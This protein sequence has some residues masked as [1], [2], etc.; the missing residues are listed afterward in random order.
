M[1][2]RERIVQASRSNDLDGIL[3]TSPENFYYATGVSPH[4]LSVSRIPGFA[5][6][7]LD[8]RPQ[9]KDA[10]ITMDY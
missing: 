5:Y 8:L 6:A 1:T 7:F 2:T 4:Q 3:V 9:Q 10:I